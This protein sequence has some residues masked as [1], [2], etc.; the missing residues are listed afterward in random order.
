MKSSFSEKELIKDFCNILI[1]NSNEDNLLIGI[2]DDAA[3]FR[4][5]EFAT[6]STD[7]L[8]ENIH[9]DLSYPSF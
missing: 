8:V 7:A 5:D 9:F 4:S 6:Q 3:V 1:N 2:G